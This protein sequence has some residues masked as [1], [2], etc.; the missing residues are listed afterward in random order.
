MAYQ[1]SRIETG[2]HSTYNVCSGHKSRRVTTFTFIRNNEANI[3][4]ENSLSKWK[5]KLKCQK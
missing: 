5:K 2:N 3:K 1:I 4:A